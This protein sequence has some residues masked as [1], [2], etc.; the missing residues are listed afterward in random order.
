MTT[1]SRNAAATTITFASALLA[2]WVISGG[3]SMCEVG[4]ITAP[5]LRTPKFVKRA[6]GTL[7]DRSSTRSASST[8]SFLRALPI[9]QD[10]P[11]SCL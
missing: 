2:M 11:R 10:A 4:T 3:E 7:G 6:G 1:P 5:S 9:L 8:P